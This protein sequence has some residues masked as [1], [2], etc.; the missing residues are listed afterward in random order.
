[1]HSAAGRKIGVLGFSQGGMVPRWAF[2]F[3]PDTRAMVDDDIGLDASNHGTQNSEFCAAVK[4]CPAA[5]WQQRASAEFIKAL[6]SFKETFAGISYTEIYS[7]N[8]E[9]V[10]PQLRRQRELLASHGRRADRERAR[11]GHLSR[12]RV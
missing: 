12:R 5:F 8:D 11:T 10:T 6:N 4:S 7:R 3:W 1:M 9:V 2:R